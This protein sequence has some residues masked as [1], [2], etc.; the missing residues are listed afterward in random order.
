MTGSLQTPTLKGLEGIRPKEPAQ[1]MEQNNLDTSLPLTN[2]VSA[3]QRLC[4]CADSEGIDIHDGGWEVGVE[5]GEGMW[6]GRERGGI[7]EGG[8]NAGVDR[9]KEISKGTMVEE[10]E[11]DKKMNEGGKGRI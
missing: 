6:D 1:H 7:E 5:E 10:R 4:S 11:G 9:E 3:R 8:K 2:P